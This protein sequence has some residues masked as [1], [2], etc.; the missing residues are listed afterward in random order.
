MRTFKGETHNRVQMKI[1]DLDDPT[2][3]DAFARGDVRHLKVYGS[4]REVTYDPQKRIGIMTSRI[5]A[6][7]AISLGA[8]AFAL[9]KIDMQ[10]SR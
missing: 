2:Q 4:D 1:Y 5:G 8:Y 9:N 6:S 10:G 7:K 3:F